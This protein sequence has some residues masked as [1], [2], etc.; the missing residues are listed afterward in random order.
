MVMTGAS[1]VSVLQSEKTLGDKA[2]SWALDEDCS[3]FHVARG[4][5]YCQSRAPAPV[6]KY[7]YRNLGGT[8]CYSRPEPDAS[9]ETE[10]YAEGPPPETPS[11]AAPPSPASPHEFTADR[12]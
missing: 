5:S 2:L 11:L 4:Q 9:G 8:T 10:V 12:R 6:E 3:V 7:C 1:V